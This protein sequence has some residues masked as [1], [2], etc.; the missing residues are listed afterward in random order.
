MAKSI[1]TLEEAKY[2]YLTTI[3]DFIIDATL[4]EINEYSNRIHGGVSLGCGIWQS[5]KKSFSNCKNENCQMLAELL[6]IW[7]FAP[8]DECEKS[9]QGRPEFITFIFDGKSERYKRQQIAN[10]YFENLSKQSLSP[11][12]IDAIHDG[13]ARL[14]EKKSSWINENELEILI[15]DI[16]K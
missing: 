16:C 7:A 4:D 2:Q 5:E 3:E 13:Y 1:I 8:V 15:K 10:T 11:D 9:P 12:E 6:G 14:I